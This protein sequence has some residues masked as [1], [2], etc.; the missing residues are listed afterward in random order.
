M[1]RDQKGEVFTQVAQGHK[2]KWIELFNAFPF[3]N[4]QEA[5]FQSFIISFDELSSNADM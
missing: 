2:F 5:L 3:F 4:K 1:G